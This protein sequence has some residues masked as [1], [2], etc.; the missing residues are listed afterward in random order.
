[1]KE[2]IK[3]FLKGLL[4]GLVLFLA[5]ALFCGLIGLIYWL[6]HIRFIV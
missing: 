4:H 1:M 3:A 5:I 6:D 2:R